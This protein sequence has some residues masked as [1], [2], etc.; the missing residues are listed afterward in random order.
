MSY[1]NSNTFT[2]TDYLQMSGRAGRR[3][4]MIDKLYFMA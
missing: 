2:I 4:W 3:G 1:D